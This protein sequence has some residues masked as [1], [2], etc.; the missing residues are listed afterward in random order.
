MAE[1][2]GIKYYILIN[3]GTSAIQCL[4]KALKYKYPNIRKIYIPNNVFVAAWNCG[5]ME[6]PIDIFEVMKLNKSTLNIET[7]EEYI[8]SLDKNACVIIV[9]N[10]GN[11]VNVPRLQRLR[12]D[13]I[14]I[15]DN[16]E[17]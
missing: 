9:H 5:L 7:D 11:I 14:F 8:L 13:L 17:G 16:C 2:L 15:E 1:I 10:L 4:Y 6:Y 3:N 12:P